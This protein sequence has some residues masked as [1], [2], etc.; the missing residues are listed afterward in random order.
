MGVFKITASRLSWLGGAADDPED[1]CLHGLVTV[2]IGGEV[3]EE[4]GTV[5]ATALYLL[6]TLTEDK[7]LARGVIQMIPCCG[8]FL[9]ASDDLSHVDI[10]GCDTGFDWATVHDGGEV[11]LILPS[12]REERV[13]LADYREEVFRFA[14]AIE[15]FYKSCTPKTAPQD[16]FD[17]RGYTAFWNEWRRRRNAN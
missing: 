4:Y 6:K 5:S 17:R 10:S 12:G 1:R 15:A 11:R 8:H 9:I 13:A 2:N 16:E 7:P 3:F 14:D